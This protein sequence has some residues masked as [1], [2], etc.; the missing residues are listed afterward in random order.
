[1]A[2]V[3]KILT[4]EVIKTLKDLAQKDSEAYVRFWQEFG[5]YIK[6]GIATDQVEHEGLYPLLRFK[7]SRITDRLSSLN[8]YVGRMKPEQ[9]VIYYLLGDDE[10]SVTRSPHLD[11]FQR[12]GLEVITLT[13]PIDS[14]MVFGLPTY[15][16]FKVENIASA[17][18]EVPEVKGGEAK[19]EEQHILS[20]EEFN[21]LAERFKTQLGE[22]VSAVRASTRLSSSVA[23]LV[24]PEGAINQEMQRVYRLVDQDYKTPVKV[25][26]LNPQ[27]PILAGLKDLPAEA[28]LSKA[29]IEQIYES[30]LLIEG[31]HPD[32]AGMI[33]RI[34]ELMEAALK[35]K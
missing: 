34:Q 8:D 22:R 18:V 32:P 29:V 1:M 28:E 3:K 19:P 16:G 24:D 26:E 14:F 11:Y 27:H 15:E 10:R 7:T 9:R 31:L 6:E 20:T 30:A 21:A 2:K 17:D 13:D 33:P 23:R 4:S 35:K 25:L 12:S 5:R